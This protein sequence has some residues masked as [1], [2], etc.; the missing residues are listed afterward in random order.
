MLAYKETKSPT[1]SQKIVLFRSLYNLSHPWGTWAEYKKKNKI[2]GGYPA[3]GNVAQSKQYSKTGS[4]TDFM[5]Q[6]NY[7]DQNFVL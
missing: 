4:K 3:F 5:P 1:S 7:K 2:L 6:Y